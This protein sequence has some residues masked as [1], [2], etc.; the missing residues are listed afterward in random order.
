[1]FDAPSSPEP[2]GSQPRRERT[3]TPRPARSFSDD[4]LC[5]KGGRPAAYGADAQGNGVRGPGVLLR[6]GGFVDGTSAGVFAVAGT[7]PPNAVA[8]HFGFRGVR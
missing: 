8:S 4:T 7:Q 5:L 2:P 1:M 6:G 3:I